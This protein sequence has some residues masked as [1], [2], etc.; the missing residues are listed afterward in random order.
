MTGAVL[1]STPSRVEVFSYVPGAASMLSMVS[2]VS[3]GRLPTAGA[4]DSSATP[5][6]TRLLSVPQRGTAASVV[7]VRERT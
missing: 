1:V 2:T 6:T 4:S 5:A 7:R 3:I